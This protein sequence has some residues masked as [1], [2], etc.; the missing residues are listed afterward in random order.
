[1]KICGITRASDAGLATAA[2]ADAIGF[3]FWPRSPRTISPAQAASIWITGALVARVGV[4]VNESP[5]AVTAIVREARLTAVQLHGDESVDDYRS[6]GAPL[7]KAVGLSSPGDVSRIASLPADVTVLVDASDVVRRGGTGQVA[8]W[9]LAA[10]LARVRP[11]VL[12][13][14]L[15]PANVGEAIHHV[16]PWAID[17]SSGVE[18]APGIKDAAKLTALFEAV[19]VAA[20]EAR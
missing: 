7:I 17:V 4:F 13:G 14:G 1:M 2:G 19:N 6:C 9:S 16:R 8:N 12:A 5:D 10:E 15:T 3:V 11:I 18:A 20:Q